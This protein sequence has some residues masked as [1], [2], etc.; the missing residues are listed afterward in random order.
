MLASTQNQTIKAKPKLE[1]TTRKT[2]QKAPANK[3]PFQ[4]LWVCGCMY[5]YMCVCAGS[6]LCMCVCVRA[7]ITASFYYICFQEFSDMP[8]QV[9]PQHHLAY[10]S[11]LFPPLYCIFMDFSL[12]W[13]F[14]PEW[15]SAMT[16]GYIWQTFLHI[17][18]INLK[19]KVL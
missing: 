11:C 14:R 9:Q 8:K 6:C 7:C 1:N 2:L 5:I 4:S 3:S 10:V 13:F 19:V 15:R 12:A 18:H 17:I 16:H